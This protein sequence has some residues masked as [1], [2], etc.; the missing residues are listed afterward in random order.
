MKQAWPAA[1]RARRFILS[2]GTMG[3]EV[4]DFG[5]RQAEGSGEAMVV[6]RGAAFEFGVTAVHVLRADA[7][8]AKRIGRP[9]RPG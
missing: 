5:F 1:R 8:G 4:G 6:A 2:G 9:G 3:A 7:G